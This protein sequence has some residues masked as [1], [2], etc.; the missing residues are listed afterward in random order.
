VIGVDDEGL[1]A[2]V[3]EAAQQLFSG[4]GPLLGEELA[5]SLPAIAA[6]IATANEGVASELLI[7]GNRYQVKWNAMGAH[8]R[9][10]GKIVTI[11]KA[12]ALP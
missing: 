9:S 6:T 5:F 4:S 8:S 11:L 10:S 1:M 12:E 3:N 7:D 2:F